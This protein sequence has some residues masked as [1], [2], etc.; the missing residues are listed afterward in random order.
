[1]TEKWILMIKTAMACDE[2]LSK[3]K[4][5]INAVQNGNYNVV[6]EELNDKHSRLI[7]EIT[8]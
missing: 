5:F 6:V 1:M 7:Y 8:H 3:K 2:S 4:R